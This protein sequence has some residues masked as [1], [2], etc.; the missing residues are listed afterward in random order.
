MDWMA[1]SV[2]MAVC[3]IVCGVGFW[4]KLVASVRGTDSRDSS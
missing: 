1:F 3:G 4:E 2:Y